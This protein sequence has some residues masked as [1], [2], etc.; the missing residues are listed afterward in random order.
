M[1]IKQLDRLVFKKNQQVFK[2]EIIK[3][4][5]LKAGFMA[6]LGSC[7][8]CR[9]NFDHLMEAQAFEAAGAEA[10]SLMTSLLSKRLL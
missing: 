2:R 8:S 4:R 3:K 6:H 7:S 9:A 5:L 10:S 1:N